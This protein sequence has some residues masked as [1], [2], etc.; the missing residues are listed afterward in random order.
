MIYSDD[1][2]TYRTIG[3]SHCSNVFHVPL[4]CG[5]RFCPICTSSRR[6]KVKAK[7]NAIVKSLKFRDRYG[8]KFLTLTIPNQEDPR[9]AFKTIQR[10]FRR[11]RQRAFW[12]WKVE[13]GAWVVEITGRPGKWHV[14]IHAVLQSK[15]IR[16][17]LLKRHWSQVS[18]GNIVYIQKIPVSAVINYLTKYVSKSE[19]D[20]AHRNQLSI[21]LKGSRL[22]QPFG[23]W[24][25][26]ISSVPKLNYCC[27]ECGHDEFHLV[28]KNFHPQ[29]LSSRDPPDVWNRYDSAPVFPKNMPG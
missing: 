15:Y 23:S 4:S 28:E 3:C 2:H 18:P 8:I 5:D 14:H 22:F 11:L 27:P 13:G 20:P 21:A 10:S 19:V 17:A 9:A 29:V 16:H 1:R 7:L 26:L 25:K 12:K 24:Q 6:R